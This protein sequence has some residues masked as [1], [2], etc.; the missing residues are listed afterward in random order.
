MFEDVSGFGAW[1]RLYFCL[2]EGHLLYWNHPNEMGDKVGSCNEDI[3][4]KNVQISYLFCSL[5]FLF[6]S[7]SHQMAVSLSLASSASDLWRE[8]AVRGRTRLNW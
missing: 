8:N 1:Q 3:I 5:M 7:S 2:E 6:H 4:A